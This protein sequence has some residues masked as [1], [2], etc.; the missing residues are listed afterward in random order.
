MANKIIWVASSGSAGGTGTEASPY[1]TIQAAVNAAGPGTTIMVKAGVYT[2]N[3]VFKTS[4]TA[5]A[6]IE[7]V[8]ADGVGKAEIRPANSSA[9]TIRVSAVNHITIDGFKVIGPSLANAI[10]VSSANNMTTL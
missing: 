6:P 10:H 4:G 3:V 1:A 5:S 7:L 2:E 9:D 8:S